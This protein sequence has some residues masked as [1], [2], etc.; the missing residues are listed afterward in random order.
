VLIAVVPNGGPLRLD[1]GPAPEGPVV[2]DEN[3]RVRC[4][5][6]GSREAPA[7][8]VTHAPHRCKV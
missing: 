5:S 7:R 8:A 3:G 6:S 1:I 4:A 2:W